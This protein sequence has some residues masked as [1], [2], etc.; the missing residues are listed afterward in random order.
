MIFKCATSTEDELGALTL[1]AASRPVGAPNSAHPELAGSLH[2]RL[3][4]FLW[5][6]G[7]SRAAMQE[8]TEAVRLVPAT[9]ESPARARVLAAQGKA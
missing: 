5:A 3:G 1:I 9:P 2:E 4:R 7:D 8:F 6:A